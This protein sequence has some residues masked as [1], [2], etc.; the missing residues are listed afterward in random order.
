MAILVLVD[1]PQKLATLR[2]YADDSAAYRWAAISSG[3][4]W[5]LD[6][7]RN[8]G[9]PQLPID[10]DLLRRAAEGCADVVIATAPDAIGDAMARLLAD[11]LDRPNGRV[12]RL[13][14]PTVDRRQFHAQGVGSVEWRRSAVCETLLEIDRRVDA[15]LRQLVQ[16][17]N[18]LPIFGL[19]SAAA[20]ARIALTEAAAAAEEGAEQEHL[21]LSFDG[22]KPA[23]TFRLT[24]INGKP[25]ALHDRN[26]LK[27]VV[28]DLKEQIF[29]VD[30]VRS[31]EKSTPPPPPFHTGALL[32]AAE[33]ELGFSAQKT[34]SLALALYQ[35]C[36][37]GLKHPVGLISY[38]LTAAA[39]VSAEAALTVRE[40]ILVQF[41]KAYLPAQARYTEEHSEQRVGA[42]GPTAVGRTPK[43]VKK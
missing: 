7:Y 8:H 41:G 37:V 17:R 30:D 23:L 34:L 18:D 27:A 5:L 21:W 39:A 25:P 33:K 20:L 19:T 4:D 2:H 38:P 42:I 15:A 40:H 32:A 28:V 26:V 16:A 12:K 3:I 36:D 29:T 13:P 6:I 14:L 24:Q 31:E 11:G 1:S 22:L 43:K 9:Q 10:A 35:G